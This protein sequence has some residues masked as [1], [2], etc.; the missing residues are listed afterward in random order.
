MAVD[1]RSKVIFFD[2]LRD[3]AMATTGAAKGGVPPPQ[4]NGFTRKFL[5]APLKIVHGLA[6]KYP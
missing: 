2:L 5:A 6:A 3:V 4:K 1:E